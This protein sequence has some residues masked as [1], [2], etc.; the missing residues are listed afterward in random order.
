MIAWEIECQM[1]DLLASWL[2]LLH[3]VSWRHWL[4]STTQMR[5]L[6]M[7]YCLS[8]TF[9]RSKL[10]CF[11][12][13]L[14]PSS[15]S[16]LPTLIRHGSVFKFLLCVRFRPCGIR[17]RVDDRRKRTDKNELVWL[18]L[19]FAFTQL[20]S[21]YFLA[22][23]FGKKSQSPLF[24]VMRALSNKE[25]WGLWE[26]NWVNGIEIRKSYSYSDLKVPNIALPWAS[27]MSEAC[28]PCKVSVS[29]LFWQD[30]EISNGSVLRKS[31]SLAWKYLA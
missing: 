30:I 7:V 23:I 31:K 17:V 12:K 26:R 21:L 1:V 29:T 11:R 19:G 22:A 5:F 3:R 2:L 25:E 27:W 14:R 9:I 16:S 13:P 24:K 28:F 6:S 15:L 4:L 18:E 8:S 10:Q 20:L